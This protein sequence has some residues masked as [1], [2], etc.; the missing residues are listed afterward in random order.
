[1]PR[2]Y[3]INIREFERQR[4]GLQ[5][6]YFLYHNKEGIISDFIYELKIPTNSIMRAINILKKFGLIEE[7]G[8]PGSNRRVFNLTEKGK[9]IGKILNE[10]EE[11]LASPNLF[12]FSRNDEK[13][14]EK[15][16]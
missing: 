15:N 9:K 11:I 13:K 1:M 10:M 14:E 8:V 16:E 7:H 2:K 12:T 4:G 3:P 5:I 6:I